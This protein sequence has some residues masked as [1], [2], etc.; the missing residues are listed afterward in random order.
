MTDTEPALKAFE[1]FFEEKELA[2]DYD[3]DKQTIIC[4]FSAGIYSVAMYILATEQLTVIS[5]KPM[6]KV[7]KASEGDV[8]ALLNSI[9]C[10]ISIGRF[11]LEDSGI[12]YRIYHDHRTFPVDDEYAAALVS[13]AVTVINRYSSDIM[14]AVGDDDDPGM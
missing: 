1:D 2:H 8:L 12:S 11:V 3:P 6:I 7:P 14:N 4:R 5:C 13:I 10:K 9:N